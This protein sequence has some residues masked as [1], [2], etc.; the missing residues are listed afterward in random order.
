M[1]RKRADVIKNEL[2]HDNCGKDIL[3]TIQMR[4][5]RRSKN[6]KCWISCFIFHVS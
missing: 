4:G 3:N 1:D 5:H 2:N 6:V